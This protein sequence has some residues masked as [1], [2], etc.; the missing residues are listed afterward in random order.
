MRWLWWLCYRRDDA[1]VVKGQTL[2]FA[3]M[4]GA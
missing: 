4:Q 3:R 1:V 2:I